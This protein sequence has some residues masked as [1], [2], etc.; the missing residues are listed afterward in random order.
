MF[1]MQ[2]WNELY[3]FL[4][5]GL[6]FFFQNALVFKTGDTNTPSFMIKSAFAF[7]VVWM[8]AV[9]L[10]WLRREALAM[11]NENAPPGR[12]SILSC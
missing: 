10:V 4:N 6:A 7:L 12:I 9:K 8:V 1:L 5:S 11:L 3:L 2:I